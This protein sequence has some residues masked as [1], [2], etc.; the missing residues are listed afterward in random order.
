M[1][2][3]HSGESAT[4]AERVLL[5]VRE[6]AAA[7]PL[8]PTHIKVTAGDTTVELSWGHAGPAPRTEAMSQ[9][10][11][12]APRA[13]LP[14]ATQAAPNGAAQ[15][16]NGTAQVSNG[17]AQAAS[18]EVTAGGTAGVVRHVGSPTVGVFYHAPEPGAPPFVTPGDT[19]T[20]GQQV[21]IVEAMKL[22]VPVNATEAGTVDKLL[23]QDGS[24]VEYDEPLLSYVPAGSA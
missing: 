13:A 8:P 23:V 9:A 21:G 12:P 3:I 18:G 16:P 19:I 2:S 1:T 20:A 24:Q 11:E 5:A 6:T 10:G 15:V 7:M 17:A 22:M 14:E 4:T